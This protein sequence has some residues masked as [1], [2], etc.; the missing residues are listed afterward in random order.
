MCSSGNYP[1]EKRPTPNPEISKPST[2]V[3][4]ALDETLGVLM[5]DDA[6]T[7]PVGRRLFGTQHYMT[8]G[9]YED[10]VTGN[11]VEF[12]AS[13]LERR[14]SAL[15]RCRPGSEIRDIVV[16]HIA[17]DAFVKGDNLSEQSRLFALNVKAAHIRTCDF[18]EYEA[19]F[20][21]SPGLGSSWDMYQ[22]LEWAQCMGDDGLTPGLSDSLVE[23][24][25]HGNAE[26]WQSYKEAI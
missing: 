10:M 22:Q 3:L 12:K 24:L 1:R 23:S 14:K 13:W 11:I 21:Y 4:K 8:G 9:W 18:E 6:N 2:E 25:S 5:Q 17:P 16:A 7:V 26:G 20:G 15:N 19:S